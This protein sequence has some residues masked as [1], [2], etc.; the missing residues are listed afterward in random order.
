MQAT[1][2]PLMKSA[3]KWLGNKSR[4]PAAQKNLIREVSKGRR[5]VDPFGGGLGLPL[6]LQPK[7]ALILDNNYDLINFWSQVQ[8]G[9]EP[10]WMPED[11]TDFLEYRSAFNRLS[12]VVRMDSIV[13]A[14]L[15]YG[16]NRTA[17]NG[18]VRYSERVNA[19]LWDDRKGH[20]FNAPP[21][22]EKIF[23]AS[24][25]LKVDWA[26]LVT[27]IKSWSFEVG[28]RAEVGGGDFLFLDPP[29]VPA[30]GK[31]DSFTGYWPEPFGWKEQRRLAEWA[32][33]QRCPIVACN[34]WND[35]LVRIYNEQGF[36]CHRIDMPR[37][38]SA[39]GGL[40]GKVSEMFATKNI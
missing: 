4:L 23:R 35:R 7:S 40:R 3:L 21:G 20:K 16:L 28:D 24:S 34:A 15:F 17:F 5:W 14:R 33:A 2:A 32:G 38:V 30:N 9:I 26:E 12:L 1:I 13:A 36:E 10:D 39:D 8:R 27:I 37:S 31:E 22:D 25:R 18:L 11:P 6:E 19:T 29:Y